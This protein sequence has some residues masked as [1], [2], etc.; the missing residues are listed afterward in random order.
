MWFLHHKKVCGFLNTNMVFIDGI[1]QYIE[2]KKNEIKN[3]STSSCFKFQPFATMNNAM[4]KIRR[5]MANDNDKK[6]KEKSFNTFV[7][8]SL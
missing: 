2:S 5:K 4:N 3:T 7:T 6:N 8:D 1:E